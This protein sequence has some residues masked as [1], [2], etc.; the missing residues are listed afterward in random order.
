MFSG[1]RET[2]NIRQCSDLGGA[3]PVSFPVPAN[4]VS[5]RKPESAVGERAVV[6]AAVI[7]NPCSVR[8]ILGAFA[9]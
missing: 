9:T 3:L 4:T 6:E 1:S 7:F 8:R 2:T 5:E